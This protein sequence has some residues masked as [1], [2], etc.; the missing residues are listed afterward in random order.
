MKNRFTK[1]NSWAKGLIVDPLSKQPLTL[2]EDQ[3]YLL[4]SYGR[5]YPIVNGIFDLR[6]LNNETTRD[7]KLWK[8]GQHHYEEW[9]YN[10]SAQD[11]KEN[12]FE[13]IA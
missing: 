2:S 13:E 12:Y 9:S 1:L 5:R 8:E 11:H 7:Q 3:R 4:S 6:L 10:I